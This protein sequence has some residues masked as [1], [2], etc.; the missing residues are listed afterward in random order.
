[1]TSWY[2]AV[3]RMA[4]VA[5][6]VFAFGAAATAA[7]MKGGT[8]V[9]GKPNDIDSFDAHTATNGVTWQVLFLVYETLIE[10]KGDL[11][12]EPLLAESWEQPSPTT[13]IFHLRQN[14]KFSNG[15]AVTA[16]DVVKSLH[17][18]SGPRTRVVLGPADGP[19]RRDRRR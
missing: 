7:E 14:A 19:D 17:A 15:R 4:L 16:D 9:W 1:M 2:R 18:P 12:F 3:R 11:S 5:G 10:P 8:L 13:Y 6:L